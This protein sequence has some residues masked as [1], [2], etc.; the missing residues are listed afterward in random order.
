MKR[1][2]RGVYYERSHRPKMFI[3]KWFIIFF[4]Y[5]DW[6]YKLTTTLFVVCKFQVLAPFRT[7]KVLDDNT[8]TKIVNRYAET[9]RQKF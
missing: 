7:F 4:K 1:K 8:S 3:L 2:N 5:T 6:K 9:C